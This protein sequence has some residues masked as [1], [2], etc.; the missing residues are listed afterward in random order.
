MLEYHGVTFNNVRK[1]LAYLY[2]GADFVE[3]DVYPYIIPMQQSFFNPIKNMGDDTYLQYF[4]MKD[5]RLTQDQFGYAT[6]FTYKLADI[7]LRFVGKNAEMWAK[8]M[9]HLTKRKDA[10]SI[11]MGTC[12]AEKL[13][14]MGD[15][16]PTQVTFNGKNTHIAFDLDFK[17]Y[18]K[19]F[20]DIESWEALASVELAPGLVNVE[21]APGEVTT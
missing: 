9:H 3:E 19:E 20:I 6:N 4:I 1:A 14:A 13:E 10:A 21:L 7:S 17:L 5:S 8:A 16:I 15:I 11:F 12:C 18:Y 2:Y